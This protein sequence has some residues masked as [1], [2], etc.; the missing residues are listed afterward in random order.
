M[1]MTDEYELQHREKVNLF[2][3]SD[4]HYGTDNCN[5][6]FFKKWKYIF[7][8]SGSEKRIYVLGDMIDAPSYKIGAW[9]SQVDMNTAIEDITHLF[10]KLRKYICGWVSGNH[11]AR[12]EKTHHFNPAR[13]IAENLEV[14]YYKNDFFDKF[15]INNKTYDVYCT[16]GSRFSKSPQLAMNNFI[17]DMSVID[18][19]I[20]AM[21][22]NH[23]CELAN[24][25]HRTDE[26]GYRKYYVFSGSF[27][28]Y[29]DS[30]QHARSPAKYPEAF[31][32]ITID[33]Y[34]QVNN[35]MYTA[36]CTGGLY[37]SF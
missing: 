33:Q 29:E 17:R 11:E 35:V 16:H 4:L 26:G 1:N 20:C 10:K 18:A 5:M 25:Y 19:D 13:V 3:L 15:T 22:H 14:P 30:Y 2:F 32:R 8:A 9:E 7:N 21:G 6:D 31:Q 28:K 36:D 23:F 37:D 27:F 12:T 34:H 24:V